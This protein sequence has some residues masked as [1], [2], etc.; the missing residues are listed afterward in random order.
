MI[1]D[2]GT[3][4]SMVSD[5]PCPY[6]GPSS[7][8]HCMTCPVFACPSTCWAA[9][10]I[11]VGQ[12]G[13]SLRACAQKSTVTNQ[14]TELSIPEEVV[15]PKVPWECGVDNAIGV[16]IQG[17]AKGP[18]SLQPLFCGC[19]GSTPPT[20]YIEIT[21]VA[22]HV[23]SSHTLLFLWKHH[24][25]PT[26]IICLK[27][28]FS[29][30]IPFHTNEFSSGCQQNTTYKFSNCLGPSLQLFILW[31]VACYQCPGKGSFKDSV[32]RHPSQVACPRKLSKKS[33]I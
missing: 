6:C 33:F 7:V 32:E 2:I 12:V 19:C 20:Y 26:P 17:F 27:H 25:W 18:P 29:S 11:G 5:H 8:L 28:C 23:K 9:Y 1:K 22:D 31:S 30:G 14:I 24:I 10:N 16:P 13:L 3:L 15:E 21:W 4:L